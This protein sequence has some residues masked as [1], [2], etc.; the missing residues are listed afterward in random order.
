MELNAFCE[1]PFNRVRVTSEGNLA[2]C[3][4]QRTDPASRNNPYIGNI[5][6]KSF[7]EIWFGP[8]AEEV[9]IQTLEGKVHKLCQVSGC[10]FSSKVKQKFTYNEY[11]TFLE[12]DLPNTHCNVGL[13]NPNKDHPACIMCER[14]GGPDVFKKETNRLDEV[15]P[16][17]KFLIP[18]LNHIHIQGI[19]EPFYKDLFFKILNLIDFDQ[20]KNQITISTTTNGTLLNESRRKEYLQRVPKSITTFSIDAATPETFK[21]IR[22][23]PVFEHVLENLYAFGSERN[24]SKQFLRI[25]NNIN[26]L[27]VHE[28]V[29]MV[30]I[31]AKAKVNVLEMNPTDGH[32]TGILVNMANCGVFKKAQNDLLEECEK[33]KV[34][35][36]LVKP[37]DNGLMD[38]LIQITL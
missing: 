18:N 34:P 38:K 31:A 20:Y 21:L 19:A 6:E 12:L 11:P 36:F 8:L 16:K 32:N 23:L 35:L 10:P 28:V 22:I 30:G 14:S 1:Y 15:L 24:I 9:R 17:L 2:F 25:N 29:Q 13:E 7:D 27:N 26:I 4:F 3:C 5:L 37:L 33:L